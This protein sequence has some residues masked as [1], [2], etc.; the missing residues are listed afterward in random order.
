MGFMKHIDEIPSCTSLVLASKQFWMTTESEMWSKIDIILLRNYIILSLVFPSAK[1]RHCWKFMS[2][3]GVPPL[4]LCNVI[5]C[6]LLYIDYYI[7]KR[8]S[9]S[10]V[11][12]VLNSTKL[13]Y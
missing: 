10:M 1:K 2:L 7:E 6:L 11:Q 9:A 8:P 12:W 13:N 5:N 3:K 4:R